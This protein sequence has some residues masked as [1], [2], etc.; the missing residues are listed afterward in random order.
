MLT[1]RSS[2]LFLCCIC[3]LGHSSSNNNYYYYYYLAQQWQ[4][5]YYLFLT[6]VFHLTHSEE[7]LL[8]LR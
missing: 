5:S 6:A 8:L 7:L 3:P 1:Q 2:L 4:H